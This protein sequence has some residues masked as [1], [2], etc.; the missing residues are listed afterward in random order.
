MFVLNAYFRRELSFVA[1]L[2]SKLRFYSEFSHTKVVHDLR[3]EEHDR[4][5]PDV[6]VLGAHNVHQ[7]LGKVLVDI[8]LQ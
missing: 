4:V 7:L 8:L 2:R 1:I 6:L 5:L 3:L